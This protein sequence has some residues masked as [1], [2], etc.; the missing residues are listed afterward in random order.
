ME[1]VYH[2]YF[3]NQ[4]RPLGSLSLHEVA[5]FT[6]PQSYVLPLER[7]DAYAVYLV[8]EGKG[9]YALGGTEFQ[10]KEND[11]FAMYPDVPVRCVSDNA[12]PL[13]L[14][15]LSFDGVDARLLLNASGFDPKN[16]VRTLDDYTAGQ[17][18]KVMGGIYMWRG[19]E[20]HS[21]IQSTACIYALMSA[22]VKTNTWEQGAMPPGWTGVVHFQKAID[23]IAENYSRPVNVTDIEIGRAHV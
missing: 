8:E 17:I 3:K 14:Y 12:E 10:V 9:V 23:F 13:K 16:P 19:Q 22:L 18:A 4:F 7:P 1:P 5:S 11:I 2:Y 21:V 20:I 6:C 15:A